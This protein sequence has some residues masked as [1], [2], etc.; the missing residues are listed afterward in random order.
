MPQHAVTVRGDDVAVG[1]FA[2]H[3]TRRGVSISRSKACKAKELRVGAPTSV[4]SPKRPVSPWNKAHPHPEPQYQGFQGEY[5]FTWENRP[6]LVL[7]PNLS[8]EVIAAF[9][10]K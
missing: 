10:P 8:K 1:Q 9:P 2:A 4:K 7:W 3:G 6:D 5:V